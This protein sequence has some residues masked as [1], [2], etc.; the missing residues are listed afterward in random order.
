MPTVKRSSRRW[1]AGRTQLEGDAAEY[2]YAV[3]GEGVSL[4]LTQARAAVAAIAADEPNSYERSWR[5]SV[6]S[7]RILTKALVTVGASPLRPYLVPAAQRAPWLF[8]AAVNQVS[9]V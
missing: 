1:E 5:A 9:R 4:A 8:A 7:H 2:V 6:R 3:T